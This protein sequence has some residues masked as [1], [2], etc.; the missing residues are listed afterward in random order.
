MPKKRKFRLSRSVRKKLKKLYLPVIY[1][2]VGLIGGLLIARIVS[3]IPKPANLVWAADNT[4]I[5]PADLQK[6]LIN[7]NDCASYRGNGS[8][9]GVGLWGVYQ[10][11]KLRYAKIAYG[12]SLNLNLYIM[13]V[14]Q[15]DTWQL[16][17]PTEY[18]APFKDGVDPTKGAL[19]YCSVVQKYKIPA[20]IE[21]F[22]INPDGT[23][24]SN[25]L[26]G[27]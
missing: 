7:K 26:G 16:L 10:V 15:Q 25:D 6:T 8:P 5:I 1:V 3:I 19:P 20:E 11:S 12:C 13:A 22:C 17:N 21:S 23:A 14:K 4:V 18:F 9:N 2:S 24:R 27:S